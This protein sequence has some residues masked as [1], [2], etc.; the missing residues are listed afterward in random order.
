MI[1]ITKLELDKI[2]EI[3][4]VTTERIMFVLLVMAKYYRRD[5]YYISKKD[6][7]K[8]SKCH[9]NNNT[10]DAE[11]YKLNQLGYIETNKGGS[12]T[13]KILDYSGEVILQVESLEKMIHVYL[14]VRKEKGYLF[15]GKCAKKVKATG[16]N[17]KLC[18]DCSLLRRK[19]KKREYIRNVRKKLEKIKM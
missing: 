16:V 12:R 4:R 15:C 17:Q 5:K 18:V 8:Y 10:L 9:I 1:E 14:S 19:E 7:L 2:K 11:L 3:E 6:I 13:V